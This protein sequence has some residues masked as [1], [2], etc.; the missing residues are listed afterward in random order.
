MASKNRLSPSLN[1]TKQTE[2]KQN[3]LTTNPKPKQSLNLQGDN[4]SLIKTWI[5][6]VNSFLTHMLDK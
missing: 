6:Q 4:N 1:K 3:K 2:T 5:L